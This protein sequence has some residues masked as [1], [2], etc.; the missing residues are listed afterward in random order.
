[1]IDTGFVKLKDK[2]TIPEYTP[3]ELHYLFSPGKDYKTFKADYD[4][5]RKYVLG[6]WAV[7]DQERLKEHYIRVIPERYRHRFYVQCSRIPHGSAPHIDPD[8]KC[9][10]NFYTSTQGCITKTFTYNSADAGGKWRNVKFLYLKN[11]VTEV[12]SFVAE[13]GD[14][15]LLNTWMPHQI[16]ATQINTDRKM[17]CLSSRYSYDEVKEMLQETGAI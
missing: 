5:V 9:A 2:F 12:G 16:V 6:M 10:I 17:L 7:N 14:A 15:Y 11:E 3:A 8:R 13:D 1:M 4:D